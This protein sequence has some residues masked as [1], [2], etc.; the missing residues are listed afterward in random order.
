MILSA[1]DLNTPAVTATTV[2]AELSLDNFTLGATL[3][4][5]GQGPPCANRG[6][7]ELRSSQ[8]LEKP[9]FGL[10]N[11]W[12][13]R[14]SNPQD[15]GPSPPDPSPRGRGERSPPPSPPH[16]P[17]TLRPRFAAAPIVGAH[18]GVV[19]LARP[20]RGQVGGAAE[21]ALAGVRPG[22]RLDVH[23]ARP[24][25]VADGERNG[26]AGAWI[27]SRMRSASSNSRLPAASFHPLSR[28]RQSAH[29][30]CGPWQESRRGQCRP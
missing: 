11:G 28:D 29:E 26:F 10:G 8:A 18:V 15:P 27:S 21:G 3:S 7:S 22:R 12:A 16:L 14:T 5:Q 23:L 1:Q 20:G 2:R 13:P 4:L 30:D 25:I 6:D 24:R 19:R 9:R 17:R